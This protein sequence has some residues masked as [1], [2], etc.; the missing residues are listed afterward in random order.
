MEFIYE[1]NF[2]LNFFEIHLN[3]FSSRQE[4]DVL[5]ND[6]HIQDTTHIKSL[7]TELLSEFEHVNSGSLTLKDLIEELKHTPDSE[8]RLL[9]EDR[10]D[11]I[12]EGRSPIRKKNY[13][14]EFKA[15]LK[16]SLISISQE[17]SV[18]LREHIE[19]LFNQYD[20]NCL[21]K[22]E[23]KEI[24]SM[25]SSHLIS[26]FKAFLEKISIYELMVIYL[27]DFRENIRNLLSDVPKGSDTE[28]YNE[29][30][31]A[32]RS[33]KVEEYIE[34]LFKIQQNLL[35]VDKPSRF[36]S[37]L[38]IRL[39]RLIQDGY[40]KAFR[41]DFMKFLLSNKPDMNN[42]EIHKA[43]TDVIENLPFEKSDA[44]LKE[45]DNLIH[46]HKKKGNSDFWAKAQ[47]LLL[48]CNMI[49]FRLGL[50]NLLKRVPNNEFNQLNFLIM[51]RLYEKSLEDSPEIYPEVSEILEK[52]PK[53]GSNKF[54]QALQE[55]SNQF[56]INKIRKDAK[57]SN[58]PI[59]KAKSNNSSTML[60]LSMIDSS[61]CLNESNL[62]ISMSPSD[63]TEMMEY[64]EISPKI[65]I[66]ESSKSKT[67]SKGD[68][69]NIWENTPKSKLFHDEIFL[70]NFS[71][72][73]FSS[74]KPAFPEWKAIK[75]MRFTELYKGKKLSLLL[76]LNG[77]LIKKTPETPNYLYNAL[78][79]I[80]DNEF[81]FRR[82]FED[83]IINEKGLYFVKICQ[84]GVWR[85][86]ILDDS[87][88][89]WTEG[90]RGYKP[91]FLEIMDYDKGSYDIWP[92]LII[93]ALAKIY[94][95]YQSIVNGCFYHTLRDLTGYFINIYIYYYIILIFYKIMYYLLISH[96][97]ISFKGAPITLLTTKEKEATCKLLADYYDKGLLLYVGGLEQES[98]SKSKSPED[99]MAK[100]NTK[101]SMSKDS[102]DSI[103]KDSMNKDPIAKGSG[104]K[105]NIAVNNYI[106]SPCKPA[107]NSIISTKETIDTSLVYQIVGVIKIKSSMFFELSHPALDV[108]TELSETIITKS[109]KIQT[110]I[111]EFGQNEYIFLNTEKSIF[112]DYEDLACTFPEVMTMHLYPEYFYVARTITHVKNTYCIRTFSLQSQSHCFIEVSQVDKR[113]FRG[114]DYDYSPVR[115]LIGKLEGHIVNNTRPPMKYIG[116]VYKQAR[117]VN[118]ELNLTAGNYWI[119]VGFDWRKNTYDATL[120]Y[121]GE[122]KI[123]LEKVSYN[124]N[125][126]LLEEFGGLIAKTYG[127]KIK[128]QGEKVILYFYASTFDKLIIEHLV[129]NINNKCLSI[130]RD[131]S[132]LDSS[133][134]TIAGKYQ[135]MN[136]VEVK[137]EPL[138]SETIMFRVN[139]IESLEKLHLMLE[140]K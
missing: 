130:I 22:E 135:K 121:Y 51:E 93:K 62:D 79:V 122:E 127:Q 47:M 95:T 92:L 89:C 23:I 16:E 27:Q 131:Y 28:L 85:Y 123:L 64:K 2:Y 97:F 86:V 113:Y 11:T 99:P 108:A 59:L 84:D 1:I 63:I 140:N 52:N 25:K 126:G 96:K 106:D 116:G 134:I 102:I 9:I 114:L 56:Q 37:D 45:I 71:S 10:T 21:L 31:R 137:V 66:L 117:N 26:Q 67:V 129:N 81:I 82:N 15:K 12:L 5:I 58:K 119:L 42:L 68:Y 43:F 46:E 87:I 40:F 109:N 53:M 100:S 17:L 33:N 39:E 32:S 103:S 7:V 48:R 110:K 20:Y 83:Q 13:L 30:E 4:L 128:L 55:L 74:S 3:F 19:E 38:R 75:W 104:S 115:I 94:T 18:K 35:K 60:P 78:M 34:Y 138:K 70:N 65:L 73:C 111:K 105:N 98:I 136:K 61:S 8:L 139:D 69:L 107:N 112:L 132:F 6:F 14:S 41:I 91:A 72:L 44:I 50:Q 36:P 49:L 24:L 90:K 80:G 133:K 101:N 120:N 54:K 125:R 124:V 118:I 57:E 77:G 88:P 76:N 29:V